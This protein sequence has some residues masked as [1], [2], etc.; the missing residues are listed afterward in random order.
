VCSAGQGAVMVGDEINSQQLFNNGF[1][2][3]MFFMSECVKLPFPSS[4][5][6]LSFVKVHHSVS[7]LNA[8][9]K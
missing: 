8:N 4:S 2:I 3:I 5:S 7:L 9:Q 6:W 1:T